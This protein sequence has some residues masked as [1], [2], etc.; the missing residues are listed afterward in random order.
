MLDLRWA[1][2]QVRAFASQPLKGPH[3]FNIIGIY[4]FRSE[5]RPSVD[6]R[7]CRTGPCRRDPGWLRCGISERQSTATPDPHGAT[8]ASDHRSSK[9]GRGASGGRHSS[10]ESLSSA[11]NPILTV[12]STEVVRL[13]LSSGHPILR[14]CPPLGPWALPPQI[15]PLRIPRT[16]SGATDPINHSSL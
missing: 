13:A 1:A 9:C 16:R 2:H 3:N 5:A 15:P 11:R 4:A 8:R 10:T 14:H 7:L 12:R 6:P